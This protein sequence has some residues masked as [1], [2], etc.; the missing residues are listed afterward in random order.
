[1]S[2]M[3]TLGE[4][5]L[6]EEAFGDFEYSVLL[7]NVRHFAS[8]AQVSVCR[9]NV[10]VR[11]PS[12]RYGHAGSSWSGSR[13]RRKLLTLSPPQ[14]SLYSHLPHRPFRFDESLSAVNSGLDL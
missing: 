12:G 1:M 11:V 10:S 5:V 6:G 9:G 14:I 7:V 8:S 3:A 2:R 4:A 13:I